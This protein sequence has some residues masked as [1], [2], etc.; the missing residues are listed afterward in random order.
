MFGDTIHI[1]GNGR[2]VRLSRIYE[3]LNKIGEGGMGE[4]YKVFYNQMGEVR[5]AAMKILD[6][7]RFQTKYELDIAISRFHREVKL[8]SRV[9][10]PNII[11]FL[12]CFE[13]DERA[14]LVMDF[15][16]GETME[17]WVKNFSGEAPAELVVDIIIDVLNAL[18]YM[19]EVHGMHH[20]DIKPENIM[21]QTLPNGKVRAVLI[22]FGNTKIPEEDNSA[23]GLTM[24]TGV[25]AGSFGYA[26]K[27]LRFLKCE[28]PEDIFA[29]AAT[30]FFGLLG[31]EPFKPN[32]YT[33]ADWA[34]SMRRIEERDYNLHAWK[35]TFLGH[36]IEQ[37][38][39][40]DRTKR[41]S[42]KHA[43]LSLAR[44]RENPDF[45]S[46]CPREKVQTYASDT[47]LLSLYEQGHAGEVQFTPTPEPIN[48]SEFGRSYGSGGKSVNACSSGDGVASRELAIKEDPVVAK[49]LSVLE[50][51]LTTPLPESKG[52][53]KRRLLILLSLL[54]L[55]VAGAGAAYWFWFITIQ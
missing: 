9:R 17:K 22:D 32:G 50:K 18:L 43:Y 20:R 13:D 5:W 52:K 47:A 21:V 23:K 1:I 25:V 3:I 6:K 24:A 33:E 19:K 12:D 54:A 53:S 10:H 15:A 34:E 30:M 40:P 42:L 41:M 27:E 11:G 39:D 14:Y 45:F 28:E 46:K 36:W 37:N 16:E 55:S 38:V 4:V 44:F 35:G 8:L 2:G 48:V 49:S 29:V 31:V 7:R 51:V 26:T